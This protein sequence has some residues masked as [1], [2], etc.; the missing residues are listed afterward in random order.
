MQN[1]MSHSDAYPRLM[2][3]PYIPHHNNARSEFPLIA[4]EFLKTV[5]LQSVVIMRMLSNLSQEELIKT[6]GKIG[7]DWD[8]LTD[9]SRKRLADLSRK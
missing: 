6:L 9:L 1:E 3:E 8:R 7:I 2:N 5:G 4:D